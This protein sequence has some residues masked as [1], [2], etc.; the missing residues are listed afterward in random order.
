MSDPMKY[1]WVLLIHEAIVTPTGFL[2]LCRVKGGTRVTLGLLG[3][4]HGLLWV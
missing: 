2:L 3:D 1:V 4:P